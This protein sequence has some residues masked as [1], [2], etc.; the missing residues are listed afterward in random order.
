MLLQH[1]EI[2]AGEWPIPGR[3]DQCLGR[4]NRGS[5]GHA[6]GVVYSQEGPL[7][8]ASPVVSPGP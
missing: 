8:S 7:V 6:L 2:A 1:P 4:S 5:V 3:A